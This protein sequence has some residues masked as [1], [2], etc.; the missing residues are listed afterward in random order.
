MPTLRLKSLHPEPLIASDGH[1]YI[2]LTGLGEDGA[3]YV[4]TPT[5]KWSPISMELESTEDRAAAS[6]IKVVPN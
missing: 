2:Q 5:G 6:D 4:Y 1:P 3:V